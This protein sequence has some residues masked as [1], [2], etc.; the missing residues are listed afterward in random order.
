MFT[1]YRSQ[2]LP[3]IL[4]AAVT[5]AAAPDV[6]TASPE[7]GAHRGAQSRHT[8]DRQA[9][10]DRASL[11]VNVANGNLVVSFHDIRI[12]GRGI[13]LAVS[14]TYNT[15]GGG[16]QG[17]FGLNWTSSLGEDNGLVGLPAG[18]Q[19]WTG[20]TGEEYTFAR[21]PD[22]SFVAPPAADAELVISGGNGRMTFNR[23]GTTLEF[24]P[25]TSVSSK[26]TKVLDRHGNEIELSYA[27]ELSA[28]TD[29]QSRTLTF[30]YDAA[31]NL[32]S[33][34]DPSGRQWLYRHDSNG[35]LTS[36]RD[37]ENKTWNYSY[38]GSG[39]LNRIT[40][41]RGNQT[42]I[43]YDTADRVTSVTRRVDGTTANDVTTTYAYASVSDPC[44]TAHAFKTVVTDP[45]GKPTTYCADAQRQ[46][47]LARNALNQVSERNYTPNGDVAEFTE[48][49]GTAQPPHTTLSYDSDTNN[50][51]GGILGAGET[52]SQK[53]C[54]DSGEPSC[55]SLGFPTAAYQPTRFVDTE[56]S[57]TLLGYDEKGNLTEVKDA[58]TPRNKAILAYNADGTLASTTNGRN[59]KTTFSYHTSPANQAGNL[60]SITP[61]VTTGPGAALGPTNYTYDTL[62]RVVTMTDGRGAVTTYSYD[63]LDRLTRVSESGGTSVEFAYDGNGNLVQRITSGFGTATYGYDALNRRISEM[64][65]GSANNVYG[66]D[67][68][69]NLRTLTDPTGTV[70]Y[71]YDDIDRVSSIT[72]PRASGS[73]T[74][75]VTY[76]FVDNPTAADAT[77]KVIATY[78]GGA[79]QRTD[80]NAS[81]RIANVVA[82]S[83]TG[84]LLSSRAYD[85]LDSSSTQRAL[86]QSVTDEAGRKTNYTYADST[87]G[88][89]VG[90]LLKA[91][92]VDPAGM[93]LEQ[94][95]Y[96]YDEAGN[97]VRNTHTF[98]GGA[99]N[100]T[101]YAYND[102]NQLCWRYAGTSSNSCGS[103]PSGAQGYTYDAAGNQTSGVIPTAYDAF[104]RAR[105]IGGA[106]LKYGDQTNKELW[107][108]STTSFH[109]TMLGLTREVS[110][111][112]VASIVRHPQTG[113]PVS[114]TRLEGKRYFVQDA[115]GSTTGQLDATS[116]GSI[117]RRFTYDPD[118]NDAALGTG[119]KTNQRF[120][121]GHFLQ[122]TGVYHFGARY[123]DAGTA[124]WMQ[125]DP[126]MFL[127]DLQQAN[128]YVY[129]GGDPVNNR[130]PSGCG[131]E[132]FINC[133]QYRC[134]KAFYDC[135]HFLD[136]IIAGD[137]L[138]IG[139]VIDKCVAASAKCLKYL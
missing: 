37:P 115:I 103:P 45:R 1:R 136:W 47:T 3:A 104:G 49:A 99:T 112:A 6:A 53:F 123:Y 111:T 21:Q 74:D 59:K 85:Y 120:A 17:Q 31:G 109:N 58:P 126:L 121:G 46:V 5:I 66:Y 43:T 24:T 101:S 34:T 81:G 65:P 51:T 18:D 44:T 108:L 128:R 135:E 26:L 10:A 40:D 60:K 61:P 137:K 14:R 138:F 56:G 27:N 122:G 116:G 98:P 42:L 125:Q 7:V 130:D 41:P 35:R 134:T 54:G 13:D 25:T 105:T 78:P 57:D 119:P 117:P 23:S 132:D 52:F 73:G 90:R 20:P 38:D 82:K 139:C 33:I 11:G 48:L 102:A 15:R 110:G 2:Q 88:E 55:A 92:I 70:S 71:G 30:A 89:D 93:Q 107:A 50:L 69:S 64:F 36:Y 12:A 4:L 113:L 106:N 63:M 118:G 22:G 114:E 94:W 72:A 62:G 29:T 84:A 100:V 16:S 39:R 96:T 95:Q 9:L 129:A 8:L 67:K 127:T 124:R 83:A 91:R 77:T 80:V 79:T 19:T 75:T 76:G 86:I 133:V 28:I 32:D 68:S 131:M 87:L 97:R